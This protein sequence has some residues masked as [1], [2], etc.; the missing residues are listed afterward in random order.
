VDNEE[1]YSRLKDKVER[2]VVLCDVLGRRLGAWMVTQRRNEPLFSD[3]WKSTVK[4]LSFGAVGNYMQL[5]WS[6]ISSDIA[7]NPVVDMC[8]RLSSLRRYPLPSKIPTANPD[9]DRVA[10]L[11]DILCRCSV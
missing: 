5:T 4:V 10:Q 1:I 9:L 2:V 11:A 8:P 7:S 6:S 3:R